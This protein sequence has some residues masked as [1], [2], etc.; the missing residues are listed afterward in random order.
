MNRTD[1]SSELLSGHTD[2]VLAVDVSADG[3]WLVSVSKDKTAR[4]WDLE[5]QVCVA[6]CVG[7]T[8]AVGAVAFSTKENNFSLGAAYFVTGSVDK[9]IK[10]WTLSDLK[11]CYTE[12]GSVDVQPVNVASTKAHDKDVNAISISPNDRII[13]TA[14]Q[15]K[16]IKVW[17]SDSLTLRGVCRGH[18]RGI[19][20]VVFS[21]VDQCLASA[22]GDKTVKLWSVK[23]FACLKTFEG[24]TASVLNVQFMTAGMQLMS[25]GAD[26]LIKLWTIKSNECEKTMDGH[27]DKVW[28]LAATPSSDEMVSGGA[29]STLRVWKDITAAEEQDLVS[30]R[31]DTLLHEQ[32]LYN[33]LQNNEFHTAVQLA[34]Q[35]NH[36]RKLYEIIKSML[37]GLKHEDKLI[38]FE[39]EMEELKQI[40][41]RFSDEQ[42]TKVFTWIKEWNTNAKTSTQAQKILGSILRCIPLERLQILP[43]MKETLD[44]IIAYS[45]R[46][47][48]RLDRLVQKSYL[49]DYTITSMQRLIPAEATDQDTDNDETSEPIAKRTRVQ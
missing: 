28:A 15:D 35:L 16:V 32:K 5:R 23:D 44:A 11:S 46:H 13:A 17:E 40:V 41:T 33:C 29:D 26:G 20:A 31:E 45:E 43:K 42:L 27:M 24:H 10:K 19:W 9:T 7:H 18:K 12:S 48:S 4:F 22:S 14:G 38:T 21:P 8:E 1:L 49:V 39:V 3:K 47:F 25:S 2:I 6:T 37:E 36:P 30:Q 34:F